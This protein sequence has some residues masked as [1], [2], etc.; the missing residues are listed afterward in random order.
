MSQRAPE[1]ITRVLAVIFAIM[2]FVVALGMGVDHYRAKAPAQ[3]LP[4]FIESSR[5]VDVRLYAEAGNA[6]EFFSFVN[7]ETNTLC[8]TDRGTWLSTAIGDSAVCAWGPV[9]G[10]ETQLGAPAKVMP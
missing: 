2:A 7:V 6:G 10:P 1:P 3:P 9:R 4:L 5:Q 8:Y